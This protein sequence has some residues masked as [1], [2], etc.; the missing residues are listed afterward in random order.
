MAS[1]LVGFHIMD[2]THPGAK[3]ERRQLALFVG[4]RGILSHSEPGVLIGSF[5]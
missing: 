4:Q 5:R 2:S 1:L 3:D